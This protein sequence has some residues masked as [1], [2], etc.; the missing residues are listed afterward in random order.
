MVLRFVLA[1]GELSAQSREESA[2]LFLSSVP[3]NA[4]VV[5]DGKLLEQKT[6]LLLRELPAGTH[7]FIVSKE[8]Y[9]TERVELKLEAGGIRSH[10]VDLTDT[11]FNPT[12][13]E[14]PDVTIRGSG[15]GGERAEFQLPLGSYTVSRRDGLL[16]IEPVF[17]GEGWLRGLNL[18]LPLAAA[19]T[20]ILT[21][22]DVLYPKRASVR[23]A[24]GLQLSVATLCAYGISFTL[25][26]FD[27]ALG[28]KKGK[29][30]RSFSYRLIPAQQSFQAA[31][32]YYE[33]GENLVALGQLEE[34]MRVYTE[35]LEG[36]PDS[37]LYPEALFKTARIHFLQGDD[38]L[39]AVELDLVARRY[40]LPDLYDKAQKSL[41]DILLRR[42][43]YSLS[44]ERL[45]A[46]VLADPLYSREEIDAYRCDVLEQWQQEDPAVL[47][48][49]VGAYRQL[50]ERYPG[51]PENDLYHYKLAYY[52]HVDHRDEEARRVLDGIQEAGLDQELRRR[53]EELKNA[54]GG[55]G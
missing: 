41:A 28:L 16:N 15:K 42:K 35:V 26:G 47:S 23:I 43:E 25:V 24:P 39:A 34:A 31:R 5:L 27:L 1:I 36:F 52:L 45:Q 49:L 38:S 51:S 29:F 54:I 10:V 44:L 55:E 4:E 17:P 32:D 11:Y 12:F 19:F 37:P 6:P 14:E 30:R 3:I 21:L 20:G 48:E 18:A 13:P 40:P 8:G 22:H 7:R 9:A 50:V 46:M 53:V 2:V 33:R